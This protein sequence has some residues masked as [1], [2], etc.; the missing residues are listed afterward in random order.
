MNGFLR[1]AG[2]INSY[3]TTIFH[4]QSYIPICPQRN[5]FL[6]ARLQGRGWRLFPTEDTI[7]HGYVGPSFLKK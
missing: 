6:K 7:S 1:G 5:G 4:N 3:I 2:S